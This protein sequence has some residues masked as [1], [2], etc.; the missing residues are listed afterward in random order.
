MASYFHRLCRRYARSRYPG[1]RGV[2]AI[3]KSEVLDLCFAQGRSERILYG[4][5]N[6]EY[7]N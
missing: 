2:A 5:L 4:V 6:T 7:G 3:M 1:R